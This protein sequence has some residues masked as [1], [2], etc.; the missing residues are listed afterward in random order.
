MKPIA[1]FIAT[2][3]FTS[4][5]II[6][7]VNWLTD[8]EQ[9][10]SEASD[11]K[12]YI[13]LNFSGSDWCAP[14]IR[15]KT[16]FFA[17]E[18]FQEFAEEN[19]VLAN[20]D[21]PRLRKNQLHKNQILHNE[22]LAETYNPDGKFPLTILLNASGKVIKQWEGLPQKSAEQFVEEIKRAINAG[23]TASK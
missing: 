7:G 20:A 14:C 11:T 17:S 5:T 3:F 23:T 4:F 2:V 12:K 21:F 10:K 19:L 16:E 13:L 8:F 18:A 9:A 6:P 15:L 1:L 22:A